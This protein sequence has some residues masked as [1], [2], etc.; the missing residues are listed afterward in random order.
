MSKP[1]FSARR[2]LFTLIME[3]FKNVLITILAS[4]VVYDL[5][6]NYLNKKIDIYSIGEQT[7]IT[8]Q[9]ANDKL[10][11]HSK[12]WNN[13][14]E[15][16]QVTDGVYVGIGFALANVIILET[17]KSLVII[18]TTESI[19]AALE[20]RKAFNDSTPPSTHSK[21]ISTIIYTHF[22]PDHTNGGLAF[23][24]MFA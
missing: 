8:A 18:D 12:I 21:P 10:K 2:T 16:I 14:A 15:I 23:I 19:S 7:S 11:V 1:L 17:D 3:T 5:G 4:I 24:G 22:H 9:T 13:T 6:K 20:L